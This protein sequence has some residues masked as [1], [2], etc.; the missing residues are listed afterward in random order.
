MTT[1]TYATPALN[2]LRYGRLALASSSLLVFTLLL[3]SERFISMGPS[4][5][6]RLPIS[7][8]LQLVIVSAISG[9]LL[10]A[11]I[12]VFAGVKTPTSRAFFFIWYAIATL[13]LMLCI[14]YYGAEYVHFLH[15]PAGPERANDR[16]HVLMNA[17]FSGEQF[18]LAAFFYV[19]LR[20]LRRLG[21]PVLTILAYTLLPGVIVALVL[22]AE[23]V[24]LNNFLE[25]SLENRFTIRKWVSIALPNI[26]ITLLSLLWFSVMALALTLALKFRR[27]VAP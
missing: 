12:P 7:S 20:F 2:P 11:S 24:L 5:F 9:T 3:F 10:L 6:S 18:L 13:H 25:L 22:R 14:T 1:L 27:T 26:F 15:P 23:L 8:S 16:Y 17:T 19:A 21:N 4:I